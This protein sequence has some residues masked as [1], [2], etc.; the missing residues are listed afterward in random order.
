MIMLEPRIA[1]HSEWLAARKALLAEE[2]AFTKARDALSAKRREMPWEK[3][4]KN[5]VF[6]G[7]KGKET[8]ADLFERRSQ[9]I[10][11]HFMYGPDWEQGCKSCSF[12]ADNFNGII[13]HLNQRDV[14]MV[15]TSTAPYATLQAFAKR[16]GWDF[17]W[18]SSG[19]TTFNQDYGVSPAPG[20]PLDYNYGTA[21]RD[22]TEMPGVSVFARDKAGAIHHTYSTY[23]RGLDMLNGAYH[24][25]DLVPKGRDEEGLPFTMSW[26]KHRDSY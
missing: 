5:Y 2:K 9:L 12:W 4:E 25:L 7:P 16:M 26:L 21:I 8:L 10:V 19:G 13:A 6:T 1:S 18:L 17:K 20:K 23:G 14:S 24:L 22:M 15:A 3:V 11:Y